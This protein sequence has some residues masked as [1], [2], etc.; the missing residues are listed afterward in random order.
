MKLRIKSYDKFLEIFKWLVNYESLK[1][2]L[3]IKIKTVPCQHFHCKSWWN[4]E[5]CRTNK[6]KPISFDE[7]EI[8][9]IN[10]L[11]RKKLILLFFLL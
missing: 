7:Y 8:D 4:I 11:Y 1:C 10:I 6:V 9:T 3:F 5:L 2:N